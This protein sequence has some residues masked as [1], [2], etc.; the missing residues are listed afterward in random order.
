MKFALV[1]LLCVILFV[2]LFEGRNIFGEN[3]KTVV[4]DLPRGIVYSDIAGIIKSQYIDKIIAS[5]L[6]SYESERQKDGGT[7]PNLGHLYQNFSVNLRDSCIIRGY[8]GDAYIGANVL[9]YYQIKKYVQEGKNPDVSYVLE[10]DGNVFVNRKKVEKVDQ[11]ID[12]LKVQ[13]ESELPKVDGL[14]RIVCGL[15][16]KSSSES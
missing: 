6:S 9:L 12:F 11:F 15:K 5:V 4:I 3:S 8:S 7:V 14:N 1:F 13:I 16:S 2:L 10:L